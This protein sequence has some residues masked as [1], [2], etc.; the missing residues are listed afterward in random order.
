MRVGSG[1]LAIG[2]RGGELTT[3]SGDG[4]FITESRRERGEEID[5]CVCSVVRT[6][7]HK[8]K[9]TVNSDEGDSVYTERKRVS[10]M[11]V[12]PWWWASV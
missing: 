11:G 2:L 12:T 5:E 10:S 6:S 8:A 1:A 3:L 4:S 9:L 7:L